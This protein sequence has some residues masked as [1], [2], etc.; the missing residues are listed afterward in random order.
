MAVT[1]INYDGEG[2]SLVYESV[3]ISYGPGLENKKVF[4][5]GDFIKDWYHCMKFIVQRLSDTEEHFMNSSS[6]DHFR[7]DGAPYKKAWLVTTD[8]ISELF[9]DYDDQGLIMYVNQGEYPSWAE[10]RE[11][12]SQ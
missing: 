2:D 9:Y 3:D 6:V 8:H 5:S 4:D 10:L 11:Y 12:C 7:M 1:N